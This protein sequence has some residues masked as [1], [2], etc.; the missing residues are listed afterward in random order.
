MVINFFVY[1]QTLI[2]LVIH[3]FPLFFGFSP[4]KELEKYGGIDKKVNNFDW[5][6]WAGGAA[7]MGS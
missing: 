2:Q 6:G 5:L 3:F 4:T 1:L 7:E